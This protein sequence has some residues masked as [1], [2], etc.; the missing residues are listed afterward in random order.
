MK[1]PVVGD[2]AGHPPPAAGQRRDAARN[3]HRIL[4]AA[5]VVLGESG[6]DASMEEIAARAGVGVGTVYRR[7]A[8]KDALIDELLRLS[9]EEALAAARQ[10]LACPGGEGLERLLRRLGTLFA[11]HARYAHLL[12]ERSADGAEGLEIRA[13]VEELTAR[14]LAAGTLNS[15]VTLGDVMSLIWAMRGLTE[16]TGDVAP[17]SWER[18]LDIHLAGLRAAGSV[19]AGPALSAG[20]LSELLPGHPTELQVALQVGLD[21]GGRHR[22]L[23][24]LDDR[25]VAADKELGEVPLDLVG[26]V[27]LGP[28]PGDDLVEVAVRGA[29]VA[30]RL[31]PQ[32]LVERVRAWPVDLDLAEHR[33]RDVVVGRAEVLDLRV[34]PRLLPLELVAREAEDLKAAVLVGAVERLKALILRRQ[35][36]LA[37]H[38]DDEQHLARVV[39]QG[40][41]AAVGSGRREVVRACHARSSLV[42]PGPTADGYL[43]EF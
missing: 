34:G 20:Q 26:A 22:R 9:L 10:A 11:G 6:A 18:F 31:G 40:D 2:A 15:G 13:A 4:E 8:S 14:A 35:A 7:F 36:A 1:G 41:L 37:R 17:E 39:A 28:D 30:G 38:V 27:R 25:A 42:N 32:E 24:A 23:V 21:V 33:E 29:E 5:R 43:V 19:S 12:L 16:A 3:Y